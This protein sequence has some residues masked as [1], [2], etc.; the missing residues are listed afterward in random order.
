ML[1]A[2]YFLVK[3]FEDIEKALNVL[4]AFL[5]PHFGMAEIWCE[6]HEKLNIIIFQLEMLTKLKLPIL[7]KHL[8]R[9]GLKLGTVVSPW[10]LSLFAILADEQGV[11]REVI[12]LIWDNYLVRGWPL[13]ITACLSFL[14]LALSSV[15]G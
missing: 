15:I 1:H 5:N 14:D 3:K 2:G 7:H 4:G 11:P 12:G 6:R 10:L 8:K 9:I 13:L